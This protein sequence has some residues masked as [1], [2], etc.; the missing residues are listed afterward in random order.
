MVRGRVW[1]GDE[2]GV[3]CGWGWGGVSILGPDISVHLHKP[4]GQ[5]R[6]KRGRK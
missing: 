3:G 2:E 6:M 1:M 4:S 5:M